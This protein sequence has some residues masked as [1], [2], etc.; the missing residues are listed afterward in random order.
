MYWI[1]SIFSPPNSSIMVVMRLP[2]WPMQEPIGSMELSVVKTA[3]LER[4]PGSRAA[5]AGW[6]RGYLVGGAV[7]SLALLAALLLLA[8]RG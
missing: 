4:K 5:G 2:R 6:R 7:S 3:T 8:W 1:T